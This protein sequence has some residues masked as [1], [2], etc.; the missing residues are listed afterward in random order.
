M[1][2]TH[3]N[4]RISG[5]VQGVFYRASAKSKAEE[6]H[7]KGFVRNEPNGDVYIEAEGDETSLKEFIAWCRKGPT[8]AHVSDV[9]MN[10]SEVKNFTRFEIS[11]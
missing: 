8:H 9:Q 7:L 11:R 1:Q 5:K 4:I 10:P 3:L 6:L 2:I